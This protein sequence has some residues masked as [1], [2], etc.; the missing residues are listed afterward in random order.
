MNTGV[1]K[2]GEQIYEQDDDKGILRV[3]YVLA[4]SVAFLVADCKE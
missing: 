4:R 2:K 3:V 1:V